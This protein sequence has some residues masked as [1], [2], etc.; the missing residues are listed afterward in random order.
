MGKCQQSAAVVA[1]LIYSLLLMADIAPFSSAS[2]ESLNPF[3]MTRPSSTSKC[4][5][6]PRG[7]RT[8]PSL[9]RRI[10][11]GG[12]RKKKGCFGRALLSSVMWSLKD[13]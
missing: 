11:L 3:P 13:C 1:D 12:L 8:G 5:L 2:S 6:T 9:G 4:M 10:E 7:R